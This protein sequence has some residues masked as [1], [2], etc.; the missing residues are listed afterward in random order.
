MSNSAHEGIELPDRVRHQLLEIERELLETGASLSAQ[1]L[2]V[3]RQGLPESSIAEL[4][5]FIDPDSMIREIIGTY[6]LRLRRLELIRNLFVVAPLVLSWT[7]LIWALFAYQQAL[8]QTPGLAAQSFIAQWQ[9]GFGGRM[10][11]TP[12]ASLLAVAGLFGAAFAS[13]R[14]VSVTRARI[15]RHAHHL[16][17]D[18]ISTVAESINSMQSESG[19]Y[20]T[21]QGGLLPEDWAHAVQRVLQEAT[22]LTEVNLAAA[23]SKIE[24]IARFTQQE[25]Q[26]LHEQSR[27]LTETEIK[28]LIESLHQNVQA[29]RTESDRQSDLATNAANFLTKSTEALIRSGHANESMAA[30]THDLA[31]TINE[32]ETIVR[33]LKEERATGDGPRA[34]TANTEYSDDPANS[35]Q[36]TGFSP[37]HSSVG[38]QRTLAIYAHVESALQSIRED[39]AAILGESGSSQQAVTVSA[40]RAIIR[41]T[42]L[43]VVPECDGVNFEPETETFRWVNQ[44]H[45]SEFN[46]TAPG[47]KAGSADVCTVTIFA[48]PLIVGT[49]RLPLFFDAK[50]TTI[51]A[52][53]PQVTENT[54]SL[55]RRIFISYSHEDTPVVLACRNAYMALGDVVLIDRDTLRSGQRFD[56][57]LRRMI[58]DAQIFQLFWSARSARSSW[59]RREWTHA[60]RQNKG[61]GFVR[62]VYWEKPRTPAPAELSHLHFTY[63]RLPTLDDPDED[64]SS[65]PTSRTKRFDLFRTRRARAS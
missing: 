19:R 21:P 57:G 52:S 6:H 46:F 10:I 9:L 22:T 42:V 58:E 50:P 28:P 5:A 13:S 53:S 55:Y 54:T 7:A 38:V 59:V 39:A 18:V 23:T 14:L 40:T 30:S 17:A 8:A 29:L 4:Y 61:D 25:I 12:I 62:P 64:H 32:L 34:H 31:R 51:M 65:S 60:L 48:G 15:A 1:R 24:E 3:I 47:D 27:T 33:A 36:F 63:V 16:A 2:A 45:R 43:T 44:W 49:L 56:D 41:G 26:Y 20:I 11:L 37:T 35:L